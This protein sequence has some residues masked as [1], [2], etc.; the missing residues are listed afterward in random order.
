MDISKYTTEDFV[1]DPEFRKWVLSPNTESNLF[2][3][4]L[5]QQYPSKVHEAKVARELLLNLSLKNY[6]L[7]EL[8]SK[9][10]WESINNSTPEDLLAEHIDNIVP[11][12][13][14]VTLKIHK[15]LPNKSFQLSSQFM[16]V[17]AILLFSFGLGILMN[18][19]FYSG[20]FREFESM[21]QIEMKEHITPPGVKSSL[22]LKDGSKVILNAGSSLKYHEDFGSDQ[23]TFFLEGEA[24]FDVA[25][26]PSR[27]FTVSTGQ[28]TTTALGTS[29]NIS[30]YE[31]EDINVSLVTGKVSVE[32]TGVTPFAVM[33]EKGEGVKI[34]PLDGEMTKAD[35]DSDQVIGWTQKKI[36]F[37]KVNLKEAIRVLENWYGVTF[38]FQNEPA[39]GLFLS[40]KFHDETLENVLEGLSFTAKFEFEINED[41]VKIRFK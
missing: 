19:F 8:E 38:Y 39:P 3:E 31:N 35:F 15:E 26:D 32:L 40:G 2:W 24:Y 14:G 20:Q 7:T 25:K 18:L 41:I 17:A 11:L 10:L 33:L 23:R 29:F 36:V 37:D 12:N 16:R 1:L 21:D 28:V 6:Q 9:S 5:M 30:A 22:T 27:P 13:S 34:N 4:K